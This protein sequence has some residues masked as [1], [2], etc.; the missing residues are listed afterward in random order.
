MWYMSL[1]ENEENNN[2]RE[3]WRAVGIDAGVF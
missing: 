3:K 1:K 2:I